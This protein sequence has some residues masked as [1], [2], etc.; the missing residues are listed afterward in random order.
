MTSFSP[1]FVDS[2]RGLSKLLYSRMIQ[3]NKKEQVVINNQQNTKRKKSNNIQY[4]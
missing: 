3:S 1:K 2:L 4:C